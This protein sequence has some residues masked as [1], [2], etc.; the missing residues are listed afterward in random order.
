MR[1]VFILVIMLFLHAFADYH[2]QGILASMKRKKWWEQ[3]IKSD[4]DREMYSNDY[5]AALITHAFEWAFIVT[6]PC[7]GSIYY[8]CVDLSWPNAR[9]GAVYILLL[10]ASTFI[11]CL[12]DDLKCNDRKINLIEDQYLHVAQIV[13][14]WLTWTIYIGW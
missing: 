9:K 14:L 2:L 5:K 7:L 4:Y 11:H 3:H 12:V 6:L 8:A 10:I 13:V 1:A